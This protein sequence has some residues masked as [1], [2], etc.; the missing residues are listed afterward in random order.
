MILCK[1]RKTSKRW[2][3]INHKWTRMVKDGEDWHRLQTTN[4]KNLAK[5]FKPVFV[6]EGRKTWEP[7]EK[8]SEKDE[9]QQQT[10]PTYGIGNEPTKNNI[11]K[12]QFDQ[13][14]GPAWKPDNWFSCRSPILVELEFG[15]VG[16]CGGRKENLRTWRKTLGERREPT[17]NSTYIWH[18]EWTQATSVGGESSRLPIW[19]NYPGSK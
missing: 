12:F 10:Q 5:L 13:D 9:N 18:R 15:D 16:F 7:G 1:D 4:L 11:S 17:T 6:E 14:R 8:P 3:V 2:S 19:V